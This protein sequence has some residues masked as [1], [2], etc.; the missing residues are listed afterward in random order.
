MSILKNQSI[1]RKD[2][3]SIEFFYKNVHKSFNIKLLTDKVGM[4]RKIIDQNLSYLNNRLD[5]Y[6]EKIGLPHTVEFQNDLDVKITE[7]G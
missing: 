3:I 2:S 1:V 7:Y 5:Y 4:D 6:L